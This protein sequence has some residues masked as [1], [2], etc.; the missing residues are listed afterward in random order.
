MSI[1]HGTSVLA[2]VAFGGL[3]LA[4]TAPASAATYVSSVVASQLNNPRGLAFGPD[5]ALYIAEGG[6][7][8]SGGP[9]VRNPEG[10]TL[11]FGLSGSITS[12]RDGV[13]TRIIEKLPSLADSV[14]GSASGPQDI[15]F[16][17]GTGYF[18]IGL[19]TNPEARTTALVAMPEAKDLASLYS[20]TPDGNFTK[21][22]DLGAY[23]L[24][25]NPN[26]DPIDSNPYHL[27][28]GPGGLLVTDAGGNDLLHVTADGG[29]STVA[30]FQAIFQ[31]E[32]GFP[33]EAVPT[34]ISVGPDGAFYV[35]QLTGFPFI[36]GTA[37]IFRIEAD[38]TSTIFADGFTNITDIAWGPD[39]NLYALQFADAGIG[40]NELGSIIQIG[41]DGS[42]NTIF[43][44]LT[45]PTGLEFGPDGAIYVTNFSPVPG[46]GQVLRIATVPEPAT[47]AIMVLGFG[48][49]G[50]AVR[51]QHPK[52]PVLA[53]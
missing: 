40:G 12:V 51:R 19:G 22:A 18:V 50:A 5:G 27:T 2:L 10:G 11:E 37:N 23:E 4:G 41:S 3:A 52:K 53:C 36:P 48:L 34:G 17:N 47:W 31:A 35:G 1:R 45:A 30:T 32:A 16:Y 24:D 14:S 20:F 21:V 43:S 39:G 15:A 49:I 25:H 28:A 29:I 6:T 33:V 26:G 7:M 13:Q 8:N 9:A 42:H 38:G 46:I 44:G